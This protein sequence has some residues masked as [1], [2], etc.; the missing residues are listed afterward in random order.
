MRLPSSPLYIVPRAPHGSGVREIVVSGPDGRREV[1]AEA[2]YIAEE[3]IRAAEEWRRL[4]RSY[5]G[6]CWMWMLL[7]VL[8]F[9]S[10][11]GWSWQGLVNFVMMR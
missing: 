1:P 2:A 5:I 10:L 9:G 8:W 7:C 11:V 3:A 4:A 6:L